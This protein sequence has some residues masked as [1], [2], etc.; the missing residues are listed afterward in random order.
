MEFPREVLEL[1]VSQGLDSCQTSVSWMQISSVFQKLVTNLLG[2]VV[3]QDGVSSLESIELPFLYKMLMHKSNTLYIST[4]HPDA[5]R[6]LEFI[7]AYSH[8]VLVVQTNRNYSDVLGS[9][10]AGIVQGCNLG[11]TICIV[12]STLQNYLSKLYFRGISIFKQRVELS[13]LHV[14]GNSAMYTDELFD[15]NTLFERT[16]L[17]HL[18]KIYSLDVRS[19]GH[20]LISQD[21]N[22]IKQL[23][24][25]SFDEEW[26]H[27]FA[28]CPNLKKIEDMKFPLRSTGRTFRLPKCDSIT[29]THYVEGAHYQPIDGSQICEELTLVPTIRSVDCQFYSLNFG[30]LKKLKLVLSN[31]ES[32][33]IRFTNCNFDCLQTLDCG[34]CLIP[35]SDLE[36]SGV[37]LKH[38]KLTLSTTEQVQWLSS[39]PYDLEKI[40]VGSQNVRSPSSPSSSKVHLDTISCSNVEIEIDSLWHCCLCHTLIFPNIN[41]T[42]DLTIILNQ[43]LL[44]QSI[45]DSNFPIEKWKLPLEDDTLVFRIPQLKHFSLVVVGKDKS[46]ADKIAADTLIDNSS[47]TP[48]SNI[49]FDVNATIQNYAVSPSVFRRKSLAGA[50][51]EVARRQSTISDLSGPIG[52]PRRHRSSSTSSTNET[53]LSVKTCMFM[54]LGNCPEIITTNLAALE[55]SLFSWIETKTNRI[56]LL[57]IIAD[58]LPMEFNALENLVESLSDQIVGILKFPYHIVLPCMIVEKFQVVVDFTALGLEFEKGERGQLKTNLQRYLAFKGYSVK[59]FTSIDRESYHVSVLLKF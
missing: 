35:W 10:M 58:H 49:F 54:L 48:F 37:R 29:L 46:Y 47:S 59:V 50:D 9:L 32:H 13:E 51:S 15:I 21:L 43:A 14:V 55:A 24:F 39:C 22:I 3:L 19:R 16:F 40:S 41:H 1:I 27:Y 4:D 56:S 36:S 38:L 12:Y 7:K 52:Y 25:S 17:Y 57:R 53:N 6:L 42:T 30:N 11:T 20:N 33:N 2:V 31:S 26:F 8:L 23:K 45:L 18:R 34:S 5:E 44:M 28:N